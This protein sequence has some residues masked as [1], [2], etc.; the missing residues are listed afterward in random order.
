MSPAANENHPGFRF[1]IIENAAG[2]LAAKTITRLEDGSIHKRPYDNGYLWRFTLRHA[3]SLEA[4]AAVLRELSSKP[5][6]AVIMG[7][8]RG[9]FDPAK[10]HRRLRA[11]SPDRTIDAPPCAWLAI[12]VDGLI[13]PAPLGRADEVERC[14]FHIRDKHLPPEFKGVRCIVT[15]SSSTG[16]KGDDVAYLR[17]WFLIDRPVALGELYQWG[18]GAKGKEYF[19]DPRVFLAEQLIYTARPVF[20]GLR[21]PV[22]EPQRVVVLDGERDHVAL[23]LHAFDESLEAA[24]QTI[25]AAVAGADGDWRV[26]LAAALGGAG[27]FFEPLSRAL[28]MASLT[29]EP[30]ETIAA[31]MSA[32]INERADLDRRRQ[33]S[34]AWISRELTRFR[35]KNAHRSA[36]LAKQRKR[37]FKEPKQ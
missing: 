8:L 27:G 7:R 23:N 9:G 28:G 3:P 5:R 2:G 32:L 35:I 4:M 33:Y 11:E 37:I 18:K 10:S 24:A 15:P 14:G 12:D 19:V 6:C 1:S 21:D 22:P 34:S 16:L 25:R 29:D 20:A 13:V 26:F 17:L 30:A 31:D 36:K